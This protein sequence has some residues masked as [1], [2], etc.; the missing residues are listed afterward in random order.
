M[1]DVTLLRGGE[2]TKAMREARSQV[3][4]G[5]DSGNRPTQTDGKE[6]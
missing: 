6:A 1:N 3:S 2:K 4:G 5:H